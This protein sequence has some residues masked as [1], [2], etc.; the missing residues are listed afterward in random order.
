M[1]AI[2]NALLFVTN[3]SVRA[4]PGLRTRKPSKSMVVQHR[5]GR[6][7]KQPLLPG[8]AV[9]TPL[10]RSHWLC[11]A[12]LNPSNSTVGNSNKLNGFPPL[13]IMAKNRQ[14]PVTH[15]LRAYPLH[16][17]QKRHGGFPFGS[18]DDMNGG[19][20]CFGRRGDRIH[21]AKD[22]VEADWQRATA[23]HIG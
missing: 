7:Q 23:D 13:R 2:E 12:N 14:G 1:T 5:T 20:A 22:I 15:R 6:E 9:Q 8:G 10:G 4:A 21:L 3:K 18:D 17:S 19:R 16:L 11:V